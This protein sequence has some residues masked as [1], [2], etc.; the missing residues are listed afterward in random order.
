MY[1]ILFSSLG[2]LCGK[3][4]TMLTR[5][6]GADKVNSLPTKKSMLLCSSSGLHT[7]TGDL[8]KAGGIYY[9]TESTLSV[10]CVFGLAASLSG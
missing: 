7:G 1:T 3:L 8:V 6:S 4:S 2:V 5:E 10:R 9:R